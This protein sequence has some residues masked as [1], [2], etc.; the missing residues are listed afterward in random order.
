[1]PVADLD[2]GLLPLV[3]DGVTGSPALA[4]VSGNG[5]LD[6]GVMSAVGPAYVLTPTGASA[7]G[8]GTTGKPKAMASGTPGAQ[9]NSVGL[10]NTSLPALGAPVFGSLGST[11][12]GVSLI[13]PASTVG[14]LVNEGYP[15]NQSPHEDQVDAWN[16]TTGSFDAG[17]PQQMNDVQF[18]ASPIVADV[19]GDSTPYVVEGSGTYD[20]RALD[21]DGQEA[22]GFPKF[23][24][25][26][27]VNSPSYGSFGTLGSKVLAAGTREGYLF[28]WTTATPAC[29][30][31]GPWPKD[32]H[33]LWN[34]G[35]LN[36][37]GAPATPG[38][39]A[40]PTPPSRTPA[41]TASPEGYWEVAADGGVFSFA[42]AQF[43]GSMG[44][45]P[46][47]AP[48]VGMAPTPDGKGYW[49]VAADGGVFSFGDAKFYGSMGGQPLD[50][51]VVGMAATPDG[52]GY[53]LVGA[54]GGVFSF[55]DAPFY[56]SIGGKPL[57]GP[58]VGMAA[59]S[60]GD[61][62]WLVGAG[63]GVFSFGDAPFYGSMGGKPL[64]APVVGMAATPDGKGYW[65]VGADGGVFSFG[66]AKFYGSMGGKPLDAPVVGMAATPD[67]KGYWL[68]GADGGV[69]SFGDAPFYGS[70]VGKTLNAPVVGAAGT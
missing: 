1:M 59:T 25:G 39:S 50:A 62:Y 31:S 24:G 68:V 10:M 32:H 40:P 69:F 46:L 18:T 8:I 28:V 20:L 35:D 67:G 14:E 23:T 44:G 21:A 53:W 64:D 33:D 66:D 51:P 9:S 49:E 70:M 3:G 48:V 30:T 4:D 43:D 65:L 26:W 2:P 56:G 61:G 63:G 19:G 5:E 58:V 17:F 41:T 13:A 55:G 7:L 12:P 29:A 34:T 27:M 57:S 54:D 38:C 45:G 37:S 60:D 16:A 47:D 22:P 11:A 15:A 6:V 36:E 42:G 52:K